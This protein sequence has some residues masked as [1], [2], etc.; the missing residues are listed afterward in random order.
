MQDQRAVPKARLGKAPDAAKVRN[1]VAP[2]RR[3][4]EIS[5]AA[6]EVGSLTH[7]QAGR[8]APLSVRHSAKNFDLTLRR[9]DLLD[10]VVPLISF[11]NGTSTGIAATSKFS[12]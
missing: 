12:L 1:S 7:R 5:L 6:L 3:R 11:E 9:Y 4:V 8:L 10:T 2:L